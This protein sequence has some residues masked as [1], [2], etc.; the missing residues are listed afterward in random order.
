M[1]WTLDRPMTDGYIPQGPN[2][3]AEYKG[4]MSPDSI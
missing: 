2:I 4:G 1:T 3:D